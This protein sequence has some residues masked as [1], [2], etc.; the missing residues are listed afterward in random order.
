VHPIMVVEDEYLVALTIQEVLVA[1]GYVVVGVTDNAEEALG[2]AESRPPRLVI[3]DIKIQGDTDGIHLARQMRDRFGTLVVFLT[4]YSEREVAD[5][6]GDL[7]TFGI[8]AKPFRDADLL[9]AV[10]DALAGVDPLERAP[11]ANFHS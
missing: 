5:R 7:G 1:A 11:S 2:L 9:S 3:M 8:L 6:L 4:A 10:S